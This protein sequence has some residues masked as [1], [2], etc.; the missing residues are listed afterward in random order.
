M[1]NSNLSVLIQVPISAYSVYNSVNISFFL[2][3]F[4]NADLMC[5]MMYVD[6]NYLLYRVFCSVRYLGYSE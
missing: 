4:F 3:D 6:V 2:G 5:D 1:I